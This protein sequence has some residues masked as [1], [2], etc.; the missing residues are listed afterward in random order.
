MVGHKP[1]IPPKK[2]LPAQKKPKGLLKKPE[3]KAAE[4]SAS[5]YSKKSAEDTKDLIDGK[6]VEKETIKDTNIYD[7]PAIKTD[8]AV[9]GTTDIKHCLSYIW[10]CSL[11]YCGFQ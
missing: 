6:P 10:L 7:P 3:V 11:G 4:D 9:E 5:V 1:V 8:S 2:P